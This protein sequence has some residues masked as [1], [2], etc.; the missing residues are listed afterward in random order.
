[1]SPDA[2]SK[3]SPSITLMT[4]FGGGSA[5]GSVEG[6]LENHQI[7]EAE[8]IRSVM[9]RSVMISVMPGVEGSFF[10]SFSFFGLLKNT[11]LRNRQFFLC[12]LR[13]FF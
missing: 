4:W 8:M 12:W 1:M 9:I 2:I 10:I 3:V 13:S 6:C 11:R 7:P 5:V